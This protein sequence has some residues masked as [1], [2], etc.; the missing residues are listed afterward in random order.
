MSDL[1]WLR[2]P[3]RMDCAARSSVSASLVIFSSVDL[4]FLFLLFAFGLELVE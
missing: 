1:L 2:A 4:I 3:S